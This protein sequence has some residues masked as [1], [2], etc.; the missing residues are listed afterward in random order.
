MAETL[1]S[2]GAKLDRILALVTPVPG[3]DTVAPPRLWAVRTVKDA[4]KI[5]PEMTP[6]GRFGVYQG[7]VVRITCSAGPLDS[8][9][10]FDHAGNVLAVGD[11]PVDLVPL[12]VLRTARVTAKAHCA[13]A[14][15]Q[16]RLDLNMDLYVG[17]R[18]PVAPAGTASG[19][20]GREDLASRW[21]PLIDWPASWPPVSDEGRMPQLPEARD[22]E[23]LV[24]YA[25][26]G[27]ERDGTP[28]RGPVSL[29]FAGNEVE[30]ICELTDEAYA[31]SRYGKAGIVRDL[32]CYGLLTKR[33]KVDYDLSPGDSLAS[34]TWTGVAYPSLEALLARETDMFGGG[35]AGPGR[36]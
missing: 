29:G 14:A 4:D 36:G 18:R 33:I 11:L 24:E 3:P 15:A 32:A 23:T 9:V 12:D 30:S 16:P 5:E 8:C 35:Q 2:L 27:Y 10:W 25:R 7:G 26:H 17:V 6:I 31:R 21:S 19:Q 20:A 28:V 22:V 13:A 1:D 34:Q